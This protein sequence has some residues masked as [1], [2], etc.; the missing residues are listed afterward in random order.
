MQ[1]QNMTLVETIQ[2]GLRKGYYQNR[3]FRG[4]W[5]GFDNKITEYLLTVLVAVAIN[6]TQGF[7]QINLEY[8][9]WCYYH[10]AFP[11]Y[12]WDWTDIFTSPVLQTRKLIRKRSK[13]RIDIA[14]SYNERGLADGLR[15][16]HGVE[17]K[18]ID[19]EEKDIIKDLR[20]LSDSM[21]TTDYGTMEEN[22]IRS[23]YM[24]F[25]RTCGVEDRIVSDAELNQEKSLIVAEIDAYLNNTVRKEYSVLDYALS[26]D[27]IDRESSESYMTGKLGIPELEVTE[28]DLKASTGEVVGIV[29]EITR[30]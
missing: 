8:P 29:I 21:I 18:G 3:Q 17:L 4:Q 25:I 2:L 20:R 10:E 23:C 28:D 14:L 5:E 13:E 24:A 9:I 1:I 12:K 6:K 7:G 27:S 30:K 11:A 22:S 16:I 15:S 26:V 19:K